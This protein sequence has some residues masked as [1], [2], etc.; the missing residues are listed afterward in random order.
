M[1]FTVAVTVTTVAPVSSATVLGVPSSAPLVSTLNV[2][3]LGASSSSV[4]VISS[5]VIMMP[6][7]VPVTSMVSL[8]SASTS[9]SG[10]SVKVL[11]ASSSPTPMVMSKLST[12]V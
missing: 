11:R 3:P 6:D 12:V 1:P 8:P 2:M 9:F 4:M 7:R 10:V 5:G